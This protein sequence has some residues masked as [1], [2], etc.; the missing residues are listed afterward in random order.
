MM[1]AGGRHQRQLGAAH[2]ARPRPAAA[3]RA[4]V[5]ALERSDVRRQAAR[6]GRA[7]CRSAR[8]RHRAVGRR[9]EP[10]PGARPH[11]ARPAA[12]EGPRRHHDPRL[13]AQRHDHAVRR[14]E[15]ARRHRHRPQHAAPSPS[16]VHPLPQRDRA[17]RCPPARA[18]HVILDNYAAHKHP[19]VAPGS[20]ATSASPS[21][22]R[23]PHA[24]GSTPSKASSPSSPSG[25][26]SAASSTRVVDLQAAI[27]RFVA[28]HN[29]NP[30]PF[31]W[32]ADPDKIIAA[33]KRG[34][35]VLDSIH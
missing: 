13:Q 5:Q 19:K 35:Q 1:A 2:L 6:R 8:P 4:A 16:G 14:P 3:P 24:R 28:E 34:H 29:A 33:V 20:I 9:E 10:D 25:A 15:R 32:T 17:R 26:S 11:P 30:K 18:V 12:E 31:T 27:N 21:T 7:L 22:S 23:R